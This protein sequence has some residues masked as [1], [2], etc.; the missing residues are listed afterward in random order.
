M[1]SAL[2][3]A[4]QARPVRTREGDGRADHLPLPE[5]GTACRQTGPRRGETPAHALLAAATPPFVI[6]FGAVYE[7]GRSTLGQSAPTPTT[8]S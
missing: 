8:T 7:P 6:V 1:R 3:F 4:P 2:S 5:L